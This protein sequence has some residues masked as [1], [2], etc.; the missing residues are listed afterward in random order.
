MVYLGHVWYSQNSRTHFHFFN[1]LPEWKQMDK[2]GHFTTS[3]QESM[4]VSY[5][6]KWAGVDSR[7]AAIYG[8]LAGFLYQAPVEL[9]DGFSKSYGASVS[10]L[11]A[12]TLGSAT[13]LGQELLWQ[14]I[15]IVPKFSFHTTPLA[16]L[17][18]NV[19]GKSVNEQ[20]L[21]DYN[22]QTY[23]LSFNIHS[24]VKNSNIPKW[25]N[26]SLGYGAQDMV[27]ANDESNIQLRHHP[28]RQYYLSMDIDFRNMPMRKKWLKAVLYPLNIIHIPFPAMEFNK[29]GVIFHPV[30][31]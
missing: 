8:S 9:L 2:A 6:F 13:F 31:F 1:D 17:R 20:I 11:I 29:N 15:R 19:L 25:I 12:N 30:Y 26:L 24:F 21:K 28:Y 5:A 7:R 22:G 18:P 27:Y 23:W 14:E 10:D 4:L 16:A 3:F